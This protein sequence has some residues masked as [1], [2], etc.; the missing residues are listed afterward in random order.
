[1][2][3]WIGNLLYGTT[4][5]ELAS[6]LF[7]AGFPATNVRIMTHRDT[8]E[9]RGFGFAEVDD[10]DVIAAMNGQQLHGRQILIREANADPMAEQRKTQPGRQRGSWKRSQDNRHGE[11][12]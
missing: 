1:M 7:D 11:Q 5:D 12:Y 3:I 10:P 8:G 9:S 2:R 6:W 4:T